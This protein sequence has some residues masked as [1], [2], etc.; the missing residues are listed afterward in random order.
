[1]DWAGWLVFGLVST[2][3]L[4][5]I[6]AVA[7]WVGLSR[8][9]LP[10]LLGTAFVEDPDRARAVGALVHLVNGQVF[11][12]MYA[13]AFS[14]LGV[15]TWWLGALFGLGHGL[16]AF[17]VIVP[18]LAGVHPRIASDREPLGTRA[19]LEPPGFLG[20]R[21]GGATPAIGVLAHVVYGAMLGALLHP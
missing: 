8:M 4:T 12:L 10:F 3:A 21:Y 13:A 16:G 2:V 5:G 7:Q 11:A 1:M 19:V 17:A 20:L 9:D 14:L 18:L 15:A 6:M